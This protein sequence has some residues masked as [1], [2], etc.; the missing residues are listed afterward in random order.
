MEV[1]QL[2]ER[3]GGRHRHFQFGET[4]DPARA[5]DA[6]AF[7]KQLR[8]FAGSHD[9]IERTFIDQVE[10]RLLKAQWFLYIHDHEAGIAIATSPD[11]CLGE[12]YHGLT[13]VNTSHLD[14]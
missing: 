3:G 12:A 5:Q 11:L 14:L 8:P 6:L 2:I 1:P 7:G 9:A 4:D 10:G 13:D